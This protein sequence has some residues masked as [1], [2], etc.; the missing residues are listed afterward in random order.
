MKTNTTT[1]TL[2]TIQLTEKEE[3]IIHLGLG[4]LAGLFKTM[5]DNNPFR[6][7]VTVNEIVKLEE[8]LLLKLMKENKAALVG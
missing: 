6:A 4:A 1:T 8:K 5:N 2:T 7:K 3:Q